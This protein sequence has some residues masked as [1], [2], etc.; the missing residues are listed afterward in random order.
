M[1]IRLLTFVGAILGGIGLSQFPEYAQQY[2]QRLAG[3]V[4]ELRII[5]DDFDRAL[6]GLG[7]TREDAF[8]LGQDL[9]PREQKLLDNAQSNITRLAF[10]E[11]A[12]VRLRGASVLQQLGVA[13]LVVDIQVAGR[14]FADFK[15]AIPLTVHGLACAFLGFVVGWMLMGIIIWFILW[16]I[17]YRRR[18]RYAE[19][20]EFA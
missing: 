11:H 4:D 10:M 20:M 6:S 16:P 19:Y 18:K 5:V 8:A 1:I 9:S 15:P 12:L 2:E 13:P 14:T 3:A 17:R 7:Q